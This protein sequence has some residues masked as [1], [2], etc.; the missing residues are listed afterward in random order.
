MTS[1][2]EEKDSSLGEEATHPTLM[3]ARWMQNQAASNSLEDAILF[4]EDYNIFY[5]P[6]VAVEEK[7]IYP[8][9]QGDVV[10]PEIV[11]HGIPDWV[12]EGT[13]FYSSTFE[14]SAVR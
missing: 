2:E 14:R 12:Y 4:V 9:S 10:I 3:H 11:F 1:R 8:L 6:N 5:I 7:K 13:E